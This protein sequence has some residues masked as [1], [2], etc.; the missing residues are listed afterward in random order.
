M[1]RTMDQR[2][3]ARV[4]GALL[5]TLL[6]GL[7]ALG[8]FGRFG[9]WPP[10]GLLAAQ[11]P[12]DSACIGC[13]GDRTDVMT[14]PSGEDLSLGVDLVA[15]D[16][17]V[18]GL[19]G[20]EEVYC[21]DC[22]RGATRYRFPHQPN[23]AESLQEFSAD[24]SQNCRRCHDPIELHNPIPFRIRYIITEYRRAIQYWYSL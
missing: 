11:P 15:L 2:R 17:S 23:P 16:M 24:V 3:R 6:A 10:T 21:T 14:L 22:H 5:F 9:I 4:L 18:H 19:H 1:D 13:H 20:D 7:S 12:P 8:F